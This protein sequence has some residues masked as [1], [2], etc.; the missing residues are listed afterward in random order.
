VALIAAATTLLQLSSELSFF[1]DSWAFLMNRRDLTAD[2]FLLPHNEHIVVFP[3]AIFQLLLRI[4]GMDS[5]TPEFVALTAFL[6]ATAVAVF[7]Y[8]RRRTGPWP[9]LMAAVL[10]LFLGPA[11]QDLLW[12]FQ[13][14]FVGSVLFGI[15]MLLALDRDDDRGDALA[16]A[17]LALS[18][19]FSSLGLAFAVGAAVDLLQRRRRRGLRR[20]YVVALPLLLYGAWYLGWARDA[21]SH[22]SLH[23]VLVSPRFVWES[24]IASIDSL[25]A[26]GT[27]ADEVV[28]RSKWAIAVLAAAIGLTIYGQRRRPGFAPGL[29][30]VLAAALAF[31]LLAAFNYIPGREAYSS[32]YIYA[33]CVFVLL[34]AANLLSGVRLRRSALL[35]CGALTLV[36]VGFNL[37][38]LREGR[39][40]LR[41]QT[42]LTRADLAALEISRRTVDPGFVLTPDVAGT[43]YLVNVQ[44]AE[45]LTAVDEYGSPAYTPAELATA[46]AAGR[47]QAD[48]VLANALPVVTEFEADPASLEGDGRCRE[49]RAGAGGSAPLRLAPGVTAIELPPGL[50]GAIRLRRFAT[51]EYPLET[52]VEGGT[53]TLLRIPRDGAARRWRLQVDAVQ[54]A[55]VCD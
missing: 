38:P 53:T 30:P 20:A 23:N 24:L 47:R 21:E 14:G 52:E 26:L 42:A 54:G 3:A 49:V 7:V 18:L 1:Q 5:T 29:W 35:V 9:A 28:G 44:A 37:V 12:P 25:L 55:S 36:V 43:S 39:D 17:L 33:G 50:P 19:G 27:I 48:V 13:V 4:F 22:L 31:W 34:I 32:R 51:G 10:L 41:E 15:A 11:W 40:F 46:P 2:A 8:V 16:C 45:Y 6:L